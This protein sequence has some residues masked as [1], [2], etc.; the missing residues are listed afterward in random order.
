[1]KKKV[2]ID[3]LLIIA[4]TSST[5][6]LSYLSAYNVLSLDDYGFVADLGTKSIW[7]YVADLYMNWQGRFSAFFVSGLLTKFAIYTNFYSIFF[8]VNLVFG[9]LSLYIWINYLVPNISAFRK[10]TF[11]VLFTNIGL[12]SLLEFSTLYW[13]C[14]FSYIFCIWA[15]ILLSYLLFANKNNNVYTWTFIVILSI[16]LSGIAETFTPLVILL[17]VIVFIWRWYKCRS[18]KIMLNNKKNLRLMIC[19]IIIFVGFLFMLFAP[20]N[21]VRLNGVNH[22]RIFSFSELIYKEI[23]ASFIFIWRL[24]SKSAYFIIL[25]PISLYIGYI[26]KRNGQTI[27]S[28]YKITWKFYVIIA[29]CLLAFIM[30]AIAPCVAVMN[31]YAPLRSFSYMS[32]IIVAVFL[33]VGIIIGNR[34]NISNKLIDTLIVISLCCLII[35]SI[36]CCNLDFAR[37]KQ[38]YND[39]NLRN[40]KLIQ[41]E[42]QGFKGIAIVKPFK[43]KQELSSYAKLRNAMVKYIKPSAM[44]EEYYFPYM[45]YGISEGKTCWKNNAIKQ[46]FSLNYDIIGWENCE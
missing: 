35:L 21:E 34:Y 16:Y 7:K 31:W 9:Y 15:V 23:F 40:E 8:I 32:F 42:N 27:L 45:L 25:F 24:S 30:I 12:M 28:H 3:I 41:L 5:I 39:V 22:D 14:C 36:Y 44:I 11:S 38:Y 4:A 17:Y 2:L 37:A 13:I 20:G 1:M 29:V 19:L 43:I 6:Y 26:M 46:Y 33:F 10:I 18:L